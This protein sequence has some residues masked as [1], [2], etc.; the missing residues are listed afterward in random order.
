MKLSSTKLNLK[1]LVGVGGIVIAI[2]VAATYSFW[3]P[4]VSKL[5]DQTLHQRRA[6]IAGPDEHAGHDHGAA[7]TDEHAGHDHAGHDEGTSLELNAQALKNLGLSSDFLKPITLSDY[8]RTITKL[9][10]YSKF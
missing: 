9:I 1:K 10:I 5:V 4:S 3:W 6:S 8:K 7:T 2:A